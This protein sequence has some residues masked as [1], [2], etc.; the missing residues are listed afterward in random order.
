MKLEFEFFDKL[1]CYLCKI[2]KKRKAKF[3][4]MLSIWSSAEWE[5]FDKNS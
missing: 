1:C 4:P 5:D 3:D 2:V